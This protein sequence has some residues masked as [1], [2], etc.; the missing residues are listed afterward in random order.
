MPGF[1]V[2]GPPDHGLYELNA[3]VHQYP[4][5]RQ[6]ASRK[7]FVPASCRPLHLCNRAGR[8]YTVPFGMPKWR[9]RM[10]TMMLLVCL[11]LAATFAAAQPVITG[12]PVNGAS[13]ALAGLP[14]A[15][16]GQGSMFILFG[17]NMGPA[18]LRGVIAFPLEANLAGTSIRVKCKTSR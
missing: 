16:I 10:R 15:G 1:S 6:E 11:L 8:E 7:C 12:G 17:R 5:R 18:V 9:I 13:Y 3:P 2:T 4:Q 14:N